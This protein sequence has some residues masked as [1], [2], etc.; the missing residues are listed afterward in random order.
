MPRDR[1][2]GRRI[3]PSQYIRGKGATTAFS[4]Q[5]LAT[6]LLYSPCEIGE[7]LLKPLLLLALLAKVMYQ[8]PAS[9]LLFPFGMR[10]RARQTG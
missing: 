3:L 5:L 7:E 6:G 9:R 10:P 8:G 4:A 2:G 1:V